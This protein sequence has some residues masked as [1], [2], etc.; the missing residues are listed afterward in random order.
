MGTASFVVKTTNIKLLKSRQSQDLDGFFLCVKF[1]VFNPLW[2]FLA[3][4]RESFGLLYHA[5]SVC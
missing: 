5:L 3:S 2:I 4:R 1:D